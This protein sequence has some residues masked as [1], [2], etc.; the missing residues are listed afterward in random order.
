M[1][2]ISIIIPV[3]FNEGSIQKTYHRIKHD[4]IPQFPNCSFELIFIDDGSLDNSYNEMLAIK[5]NDASVKLIRFT[6][7]FGQVSAFYAGYE[8]S[9]GRGI[10][11]ISADMQEPNELICGIIESYINNDALIIAGKRIE[12][13]DGFQRNLTS[14]LFYNAMRQLSFSSMPDGGFDVV[15][16]DEKVKAFILSLQESNPFWQGQL[17]WSGFSIKFI[18]YTRLKRDIGKS[19]WTISKRIKYLLDGVLN[20]SYAPLRFFS[21][22]GILSFGVGILYAVIIVIEYFKG[23]TPFNGWAPIMIIILLF[24]GLQLMLT[25]LIGEYLWRTLEQTKKRPKYVVHEVN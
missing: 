1:V 17:L 16:I 2:D 9:T 13:N 4:I 18:P 6:R 7:N 21:V 25:G 10:L 12:R 23:K 24:S 8:F 22:I 14:K 3:Y 20:Y 11:N 19:R 5:S 15:L